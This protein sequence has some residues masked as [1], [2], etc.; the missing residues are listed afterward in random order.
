MTL[1]GFLIG[2][3]DLALKTRRPEGASDSSA[4]VNLLRFH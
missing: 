2:L 1:V 3:I 4:L